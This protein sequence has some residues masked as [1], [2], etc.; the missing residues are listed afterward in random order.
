MEPRFVDIH[1]HV[2][3][4]G[5]DGVQNVSEGLALARDAFEHGTGL[6]YATPHVSP[7]LPLTEERER[8]IRKAFAEL[9]AR[10]PLALR[11]G[12]ELTPM[13]AFLDEDPW[14]YVL[15]ETE[16]VLVEIPFVGSADVFLEV[17]EWIEH[18]GL[19]P[20]V[21]HPER[22]EAVLTNPALADE[23]AERGWPLQVNATSLLGYHSPEMKRHGWRLVDDGLASFVASDGHRATRPM[24]LDGAYELTHA[25]VGE[26]KASRLFDGSALS[27]GVGTVPERGL[28]LKPPQSTPAL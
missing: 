26:E 6:L 5:D 24:L 13:R 21:A 1:S 2:V 27:P 9:R 7:A 3:P 14:R 19:T 12:F 23:L 22:T 8:R 20:I 10:A 11:L 25:R 16:Y 17:G 4:S 28:S 18:A 15:E